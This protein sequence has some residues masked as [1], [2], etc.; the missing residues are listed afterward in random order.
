VEYTLLS[1]S[2]RLNVS[3]SIKDRESVSIQQD[4]GPIIGE[5]GGRTD[6]KLLA[7]FDHIFTKRVFQPGHR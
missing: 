5:R 7:D 1:K 4:P 2:N 3:A 6:V